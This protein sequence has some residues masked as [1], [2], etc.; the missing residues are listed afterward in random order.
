MRTTAVLD[1]DVEQLVRQRMNEQGVSFTRAL[2]DAIRDGA[3]RRYETPTFDMGLP[4]MDL[5]KSLRIA[6][7]LEDAHLARAAVPPSRTRSNAGSRARVT[8]S[9]TAYACGGASS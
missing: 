9:A 6:G 3:G 8:P 7:D 2:N 1:E 4:A 5:S